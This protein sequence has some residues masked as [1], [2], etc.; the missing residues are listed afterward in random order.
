[1][2]ITSPDR[3]ALLPE[4]KNKAQILELIRYSNFHSNF[5][6]WQYDLIQNRFFRREMILFFDKDLLDYRLFF[7]TKIQLLISKLWKQRQ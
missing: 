1:M 2:K 6:V 3:I 5:D 7:G 4:N